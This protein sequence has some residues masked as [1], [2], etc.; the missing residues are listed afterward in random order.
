[1]NPWIALD[2][3]GVL[4]DYHQA[5]ADAWGR[6]FGERPALRDPQA[7]WPIDRWNVQRVSGAQ[8]ERLRACFDDAFWGSIPALPGALDACRQLV[9][10]GCRLVCVSAIDSRLAAARERNL[11]SLGFPLEGLVATGSSAVEGS[12]KAQALAR[13]KPAAF[14]DDYLPYHRGVE[15]SIH[16]ALILREPNGS[17]NT[18]PDLQQVD[19]QHRD[20]GAFA[21]M[22]LRTA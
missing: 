20:L 5:Y 8:L 1:M 12:P 22:W 16:K 4:L 9:A 11:A 17:P 19:S 15:S 2:A 10:A 3:D 14:V 13:L 21:A 6:A 18:G 7:Y